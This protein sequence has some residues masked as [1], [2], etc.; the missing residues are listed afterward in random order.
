[1]LAIKTYP[2]DSHARTAGMPGPDRDW[3]RATSSA[4]QESRIR[5][6]LALC[7]AI[8]CLAGVAL[9][10]VL[11]S[12]C[13]SRPAAR[14]PQPASLVSKAVE[15]SRPLHPLSVLPGGAYSTSELQRKVQAD[16]V[17]RRSFAA[18]AK[19]V[20]DPNLLSHVR[21]AKVTENTRLHTQ[22]RAG[23]KL[24]W[25]E[26]PVVVGVGETVFVHEQTGEM[27]IRAR[28]GNALLS[29]LP[30]GAA[31]G[32]A[33][34]EEAE[35]T[36]NAM[37]TPLRNRPKAK[38]RRQPAGWSIGLLGEP[39]API[40]AMS[41]ESPELWA[42][43]PPMYEGARQEGIMIPGFAGGKASLALLGK[44]GFPWWPLVPGVLSAH[45]HK[46]PDKPDISVPEPESWVLLGL[47][48][49]ATLLLLKHL[50]RRQ[51][52]ESALDKNGLI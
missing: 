6:R 28:C 36:A 12:G 46:T 34:P 39:E 52:R 31:I 51:R 21:P 3:H 19:Q 40:P 17:A 22:L 1:M 11:V 32:P 50:A 49:G 4:G 2:N 20:G 16:P 38:G 15:P 41:S 9:L 23:K 33:T 5:P 35:Q 10:V 7:R 44:H 47:T 18:M 42:M 8:S 37:A 29:E 13:G 27:V 43:A 45:D 25:S 26:R 48:F 30:P 14:L 24:F